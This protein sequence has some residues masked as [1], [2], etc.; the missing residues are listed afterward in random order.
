MKVE[1]LIAWEDGTWTTQIHEIR[2]ASGRRIPRSTDR[3]VKWAHDNLA[4]QAQFRRAVL[5]AVYG[6]PAQDE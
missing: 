6:F 2:A 1:Y 5:F 3:L 4:G